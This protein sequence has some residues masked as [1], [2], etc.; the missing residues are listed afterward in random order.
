MALD[1]IVIANIVHDLNTLLLDS[2]I[3]KIAQPEED[4]LLLTLKSRQGQFR[5]VLS[6]SAS[7]PLIYLAEETKK[8]PLTAPNFCMLLRKHI[9]NGRITGIEQPEFERIVCFTIEH[10]DDLGD[11]REK[12]L[13][14]EIMGK[15][16]NII[17]C[18]DTG[19]IIDSIKH[20]PAYVSSVREVLPGR[21]YF[22]P[23][24]TE[25]CNPLTVGEADFW[26]GLTQSQ[27]PLPK[28]IYSCLTGISPLMAR[29]ICLRAGIPE[30]T[31][32]K[33]LSKEAQDA[34]WQQFSTIIETIVAARFQPHIFYREGVPL[35]FSSIFLEQYKDCEVR[36]CDSISRVL[37]EFY[38]ARDI[39]TRI[40]QKSTDLRKIT[41]TALDRAIKK[42][43]L[44]Q[45]QLEDSEKKDT[46]RIYGELLNTYGYN[47][48]EGAKS[49]E[50]LNYYTNEPVE[51][52]LDSQL[53]PQE[54]AVRYFDKYN[55]LKRT[56]EHL[57][58][59]I[60][61]AAEE[62]DHLQSIAASLDIALSEEDLAQIKEELTEYGYIR[63]RGKRQKMRTTSK[64]FH[65]ISS[66][67]FHMYVGKNNYQN[68]D[69]TFKQAQGG[70]WW[71]H[72]KKIPGS[73]V[74]VKSGG[75]QLPDATFEEA[76]RLAAYY[77]SARDAKKVE[78]DYTLKKN[79]KK[80]NGSKPGF[81]VYY[82]NYSMAIAPDISHIQEIKEHTGN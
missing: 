44:Q 75:E 53:T 50:A 24:T 47:V 58:S 11:L 59:Q 82:T 8:A 12:K 70:D 52:P 27:F 79:V 7:L 76:A 17:F 4:E 31:S 42:H 1:G 6:A 2:R 66:D 51:I 67:G 49:F 3:S 43:S 19:K 68:E 60:A 40:R 38:A 64:P 20:I 33:A 46:Y 37:Q 26:A 48:P 41:H 30:N 35:E 34:L 63:S 81:V 55:K 23:K 69:L 78:I 80:P 25:K 65:Y 29:E 73:H 71:F 16:S 21:Q 9:A 45:K 5:L 39:V 74:I 14:I 15:H 61:L 77:S 10:R 28:A 72:A 18:D 57:T 32:P 13:I 56:A 36:P 62:I 22:I 54:N